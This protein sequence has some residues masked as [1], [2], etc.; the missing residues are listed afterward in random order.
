MNPTLKKTKSIVNDKNIS[1]K[2]RP[3]VKTLL[4][5][6]YTKLSKAKEK[7]VD[8]LFPPSQASIL[9]TNS[10]EKEVV[11]AQEIPSFIKVII[12]LYFRN[13]YLKIILLLIFQIML[14]IM[15]GKDCLN[16]INQTK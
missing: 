15:Y 12:I 1:F 14:I 2:P 6:N 5:Q 8:D 11:K 16:Y 13:N 7:F 9:S 3:F 10:K 4:E